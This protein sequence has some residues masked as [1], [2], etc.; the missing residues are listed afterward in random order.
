[1][2]QFALIL[3]RNFLKFSKEYRD[4]SR[5]F[6]EIYAKSRQFFE[7]V[8]A[9]TSELIAG[10]S[11]ERSRQIAGE[12]HAIRRETTQK[13]IADELA[14]DE[15]FVIFQRQL[16]TAQQLVNEALRKEAVHSDVGDE[17]Q[18]NKEG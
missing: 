2:S 1:M 15:S 10:T 18:L 12:L 6:E 9:V 11:S 17:R 13:L 14:A 16:H 7:K 5:G 3:S 4:I 8:E